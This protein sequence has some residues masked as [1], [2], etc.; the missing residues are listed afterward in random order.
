MPD[1]YKSSATIIPV[2]QAVGK[3]LAHDITEIRPGQFKGAA[4][5]K[6]HIITE[7]DI[8]HLRRLG[9][10]HLFV[11]HIGA[12]E[13]HEDDA[14]IRLATALAGPGIVFGNE[15]DTDNQQNLYVRCYICNQNNEIVR[16]KKIE[17]S[18][19]LHH[20]HP[21]NQIQETPR[22]KNSVPSLFF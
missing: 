5:K 14:A 9:K 3:V 12:G 11:L 19:C 1:K 17:N 16:G 20:Y 21:V 8:P 13:V 7:A 22:Y 2:D 10:E 6:G 4:F 18:C 15:K